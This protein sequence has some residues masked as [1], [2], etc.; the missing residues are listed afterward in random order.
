MLTHK[1]TTTGTENCYKC[2][3]ISNPLIH[4]TDV[5]VVVEEKQTGPSKTTRLYSRLHIYIW[6]HVHYQ[7]LQVRRS[8]KGAME[9]QWE[10]WNSWGYCVFMGGADS[11]AGSMKTMDVV[12][13]CSAF[14]LLTEPCGCPCKL[15]HCLI[16]LSVF[17]L[18]S[19]QE[20]RETCL[21]ENL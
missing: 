17:Y 19:A 16:T 12:Y 7:I 8:H 20:N 4:C 11:Q 10:L 9:L 1:W 14:N 13:S 5:V 21:T 3:C 6:T 15:Q 18:A 2:G